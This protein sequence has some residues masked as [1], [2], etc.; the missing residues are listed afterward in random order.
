MYLARYTSHPT[1]GRRLIAMQCWQCVHNGWIAITSSRRPYWL[2]QSVDTTTQGSIRQLIL[3]TLERFDIVLNIGWHT[4]DNATSNDKC[5]EV[6]GERLAEIGVKFEPSKRR[7]RCMGHIINLSL[8]AFLLASSKEA[9]RAALATTADIPGED[10]LDQFSEVLARRRT[11]RT[12]L[13]AATQSQEL[14]STR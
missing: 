7:I 9:L 10:L 11:S 14:E 2:Y 6:I 8:Q 13:Q 12:Q 1:S 4:G 3:Q 5:L